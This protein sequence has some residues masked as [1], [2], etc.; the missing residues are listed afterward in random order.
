MTEDA[1]TTGNVGQWYLLRYSGSNWIPLKLP[2]PDF[3]EAYGDKFE[4]RGPFHDIT[5]AIA[6]IE[7]IASIMNAVKAPTND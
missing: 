6:E 1:V 5:T 4:W 2:S 3:R 7:D